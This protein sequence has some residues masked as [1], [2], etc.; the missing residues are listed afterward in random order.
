MKTIKATD[1]TLRDENYINKWNKRLAIVLIT[2]NRPEI[3][4]SNLEGCAQSLYNFGIDFIVYESSANEYTHE[5]V[6]KYA[7]KFD[8]IK[9]G[10]W[11]GEFGGVSIDEKVISAYKKYS[12]EYEYIWIMR[13]GLIITMDLIIDKLDQL[14]SANKDLIVLDHIYRDIKHHGSKDYTDCTI[15]F[16]EQ[17]VHM[18]TLGTYI[19]KSSFIQ[20][21]IEEIPLSEK[22]CGMHF[23]LAF[24]HYYA[25]HDVNAASYVGE[26]WFG[27][28]CVS[29]APFWIEKTL[30]QWGPQWMTMIDSLPNIYDKYKKEVYKVKTADFEPY[31]ILFL[32]KARRYGGLNF[33][34]INTH[35]KYFPYVCKIPLWK[36]YAIAC[37]PPILTRTVE[38]I[39][40]KIKIYRK[41]RR[42]KAANKLKG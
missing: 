28:Y 1:S 4:S 41:R 22:T 35:K 16:E 32:V 18:I 15:L 6:N 23:P 11:N 12:P 14:I 26:P 17:C 29:E 20:K 10:I 40:I 38:K 21:V 8:N 5:V 31:S 2:A 9:Y 19:V 42:Y 30:W 34:L 25:N 39:I 7:S 13:D 33:S 3:V 37:I 27:N 36:F 24:F